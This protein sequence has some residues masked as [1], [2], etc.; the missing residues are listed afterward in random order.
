M[1]EFD[2]IL[3]PAIEIDPNRFDWLCR[4]LMLPSRFRAPSARPATRTKSSALFGLSRTS[5]AS[6]SRWL[7]T[8]FTASARS[9]PP[10]IAS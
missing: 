8:G 5:G 10:S 9:V 4:A 2:S 7:P 1:P 6:A 3:A